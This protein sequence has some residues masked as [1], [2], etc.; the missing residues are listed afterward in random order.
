MSTLIESDKNTFSSNRPSRKLSLQSAEQS[1][2]D[3][4]RIIPSSKQ[5]QPY[6]GPKPKGGQSKRTAELSQATLY[7]LLDDNNHLESSRLLRI[8]YTPVERVAWTRS[9]GT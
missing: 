6:T 5:T 3:E 1:A 7:A 4:I 2:P 8:P 9:C